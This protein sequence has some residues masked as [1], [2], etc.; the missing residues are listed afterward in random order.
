LERK[1]LFEQRRVL[2]ELVAHPLPIHDLTVED[3]V[4]SLRSLSD[5]LCAVELGHHLSVGFASGS[6]FFVAFFEGAGKHEDGLPVH[7]ELGL[8][9]GGAEAA[10]LER[11]WAEWAGESVFEVADVLCQSVVLGV[12]VGF[13]A[14]TEQWLI[15]V[16]AV[17]T[18]G[19]GS[20][21][22]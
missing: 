3:L 12:K 2:G 17:V 15:A 8:Q 7:V 4:A 9:G 5:R 13:S 6:K 11:V 18:S 21:Y 16:D 14:S 1:V 10:A 22:W 20:P 19:E